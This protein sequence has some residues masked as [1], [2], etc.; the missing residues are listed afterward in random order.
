MDGKEQLCVEVSEQ[1]GSGWLA[2]VLV[3]P[4]LQSVTELAADEDCCIELGM[5]GAHA[6]LLELTMAF[7]MSEVDTPEATTLY[8]VCM[9]D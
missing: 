1:D 5:R 7:S 9:G 6:P 4:A 8:Q 2:N 3:T